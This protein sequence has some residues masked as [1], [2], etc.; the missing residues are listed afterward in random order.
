MFISTPIVNGL[1][2]NAIVGSSCAVRFV[3]GKDIYAFHANVRQV[4][5]EALHYVVLPYP[6]KIESVAVRQSERVKAFVEARTSI[7]GGDGEEMVNMV[8]NISSSGVLL[9]CE[10]SLGDVD[11]DLIVKFKL[12]FAGTETEVCIEGTIRNV[13]EQ[14]QGES[15]DH[16]SRRYGIMFKELND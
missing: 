13:A 15:E 6:E 8:R 9:V 14:K 4:H 16:S 7:V 3:S 1:P 12:P 2:V 11:V 10:K 5:N